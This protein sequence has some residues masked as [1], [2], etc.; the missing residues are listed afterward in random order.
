MDK[1]EKP[2]AVF[3][4]HKTNCFEW[5]VDNSKVNMSSHAMHTLLSWT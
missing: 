3:S 2:Y 1:R 5:I 4:I